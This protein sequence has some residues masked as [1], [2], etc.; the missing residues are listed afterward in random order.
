M[1]IRG[2]PR[3]IHDE[4]FTSWL[5]R[6]AHNKHVKSFNCEMGE[7][8]PS[9]IS[10]W[11]YLNPDFD[12]DFNFNNKT[13][14]GLCNGQKLP[15]R[16]VSDFF[17]ARSSH[18]SLPQYRF[19]FCTQCIREDI[20]LY[21]LP[22]WRKSWCYIGN[23]ICSHH[24]SVLSITNEIPSFYKSWD[25]FAT[26]TPNDPEH[27]YVEHSHRWGG[28]S[29]RV[30]DLSMAI[31]IQTWLSE[32]ERKKWCLLPGDKHPVLSGELIVVL[33]FLMQIFLSSRTR[34]RS[35]GAARSLFNEG[36]EPLVY[37]NLNYRECMEFGSGSA[38]PYH[39]MIAILM[40]GYV[41]RLL[42]EKDLLRLHHAAS[43]FGFTWPKS[44]EE[45]G[46]CSP[47]FHSEG[48]YLDLIGCF[49]CATGDLQKRLTPFLNGLEYA[50]YRSKVLS[51]AQVK[52]WK[53]Q[54]PLKTWRY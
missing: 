11:P 26:E 29:S 18:L 1:K 24:R 27:P 22:V 44:I 8:Y 6:S 43:A 21:G 28:I 42:S 7:I 5:F 3:A 41:F 52:F 19:S 30:L 34:F 33:K 38:S 15:G 48:E 46:Y 16:L 12:P 54:F 4:T 2:W 39:R 25:A 36:S 9:A 20:K 49:S 32:L 53:G 40:V 31:K 23:P 13:F 10:C 14:E 37:E 35:P 51:D 50:A 47:W 45:L 17:G